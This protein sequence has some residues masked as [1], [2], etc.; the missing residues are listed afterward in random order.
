MG[1]LTPIFK[2]DWP[3][4]LPPAS[5]IVWRYLDLW[6]FESM[7]NTSSLYFCRC[8]K[9]RDP[10]EG[11]L[12]KRGIHRTSDSDRA[13]ADAYPMAEDYDKCVAAQEITRGCMFVNSWH[14]NTR[15]SH[16]MWREYTTTSDSVVITASVKALQRIIPK[17]EVTMSAVTYV[18]EDFPRTEFD[19]SSILFYKD[20]SFSY[21]REL[22]L[23]RPLRDGEEVFVDKKEDFGRLIPVNLRLLIHRVIM[24]GAIS[25]S[26]RKHVTELVRGFCGRTIVQESSL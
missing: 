9:F 6:K 25:D 4:K 21:E 13:F 10:L 7:L 16:R 18:S 8:D 22:R 3:Y 15:E 24:N 12:S 5:Q 11:R 20:L 23:L 19:H 17:R 14:M 1:A 26:A 2:A